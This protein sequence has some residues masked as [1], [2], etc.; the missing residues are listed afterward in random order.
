MSFVETFENLSNN[1]NSNFGKIY[2]FL[3]PCDDYEL[4]EIIETSKKPQGSILV[5]LCDFLLHC[6]YQMSVSTTALIVD[7]PEATRY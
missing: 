7:F 1:I 3:S 6:T 4:E 2:K 5:T